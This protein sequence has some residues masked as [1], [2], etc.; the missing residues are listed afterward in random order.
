MTNADS[1]TTRPART[2][3]APTPTGALHLGNLRTFLVNWA[4]ARREGWE[5]L[6]RIEDLDSP[7]TKPGSD[8]QIIDIL[9]WI[10]IDWDRGP[11]YQLPH[12]DRYAGA[13]DRL[14]QRG[15]LFACSCTRSEIADSMEFARASEPDPNGFTGGRELRYPGTCRDRIIKEGWRERFPLAGIESP[16]CLRILTEDRPITLH[17]ALAG[18]VVLNPAREVGDIVVVAKSGLPAYQLAVVVD[19]LDQNMTH[20]VRGNDLFSSTARQILIY[21]LLGAADRIPRWFHLPLIIGPDGRKLAKRHG[22]SRVSSYR[23]AGTSVERIIGLMAYWCGITASRWAMSLDEF[24][25][26]LDVSSIP[27]DPIVFTP[28]DDA[29]LRG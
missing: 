8:R 3:L 5:I 9:E 12:M 24:T 16:D 11:E 10:G 17:D 26:A 7:R 22:D 21:R 4:L 15:L 14:A 27:Y 25:A 2:R 29:F 20:V 18:P 28:E 6:L 19:D 13:L 23:D 1:A